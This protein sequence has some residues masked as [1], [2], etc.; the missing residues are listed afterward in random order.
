M[1]I[2]LLR[3][4]P[5]KPSPPPR[6]RDNRRFVARPVEG[7]SPEEDTLGLGAGVTFGEEWWGDGD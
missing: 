6:E 1:S 3:S 2:Y 5:K 4:R 7:S